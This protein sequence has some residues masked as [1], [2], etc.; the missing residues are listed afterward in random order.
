M[1]AFIAADEII[2]HEF[3]RDL[4][5]LLE[6]HL[7]GASIFYEMRPLI[8]RKKMRLMT[9]ACQLNSQ[10]GIEQFSTRL[11]GLLNKNLR[12]IDNVTMLRRAHEFGMGLMWNLL[13]GIP[14]ERAADYE[15]FLPH[16]WRLRHFR[17]PFLFRITVTRFSPYY[18][19]P[20]KHGIRLLGPEPGLSFAFPV[21]RERLAELA[22]NFEYAYTDGYDPIPVQRALEKEVSLWWDSH[23]DARLIASLD[24]KAVVISDTRNGRR[25]I[26]RLEENSAWVY[27]LLEAPMNQTAICRLLL[28]RNPK[29]Y[30]RIGGKRGIREILVQLDQS[31]LIWRE[32]RRVV[33]LGLP[34][35][36]GFWIPPTS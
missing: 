14:G 27:R 19:E 26:H 29:V 12:G 22:F 15:A 33:A 3:W 11:L 25:T 35:R 7:P 1:D 16:L 21:S 18:N 13:F 32:D 9:S 24:G 6:R 5:P 30:L 23:S 31:G 36:R 2:P 10:P 4:P 17:P 8:A 20:E 28:K 34:V